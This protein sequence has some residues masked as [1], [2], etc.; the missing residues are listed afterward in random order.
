MQASDINFIVHLCTIKK[1]IPVM[2]EL[3]REQLCKGIISYDNFDLLRWQHALQVQENEL[4]ERF[5]EFQKRCL[6]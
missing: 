4:N 1:Y 5:S 6:C 3:E 2:T